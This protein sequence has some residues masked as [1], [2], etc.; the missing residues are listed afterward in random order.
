MKTLLIS[1]ILL[2]TLSIAQANDVTF[3][4]NTPVI[5]QSFATEEAPVYDPA[6]SGKEDIAIYLQLEAGVKTVPEAMDL[7]NQALVYVKNLEDFNYLVTLPIPSPSDAYVSAVNEFIV[8]NAG[9][10]FYSTSDLYWLKVLEGRV[11]LVPQ[12]MALRNISF[13]TSLTIYDFLY[14]IPT[15]IKNPSDAYTTE[16]ANFAANNVARVI[17][18]DT[19]IASIIE[20]E[21]FVK[22]VNQ[23][24]TV[25]NA[26]L[27]AVRTKTDLLALGQFSNPN[28]SPAYQ[29]AVN[30][31]L[32]ANISK[33][34]TR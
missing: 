3:T 31:F 20:V 11:R 34:P 10:F 25:K 23:A 32:R 4:G 27:I 17:T 8:R 21:K 29:Q 33:Y 30:N 5:L 6:E 15:T 22:T 24:M 9:Q 2:G 13:K 28:P 16:I 1:L 19:P 18:A 12:A 26:G 7:K 14:I